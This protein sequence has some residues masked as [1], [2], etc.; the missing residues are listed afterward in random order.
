MWLRFVTRGRARQTQGMTY[1]PDELAT[2]LVTDWKMRAACIGSDNHSFFPGP[3]ADPNLVAR[4][5]AICDAC[6]VI[7]E[8]LEYAF[9]TN[10]ISGIWGGTTEDERRSLRRKWLAVRRRLRT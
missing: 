5:K 8:C 3:D 1:S 6:P 2:A 4:A 7:A 10:Q 9:E